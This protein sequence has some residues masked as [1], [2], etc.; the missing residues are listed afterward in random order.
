MQYKTEERNHDITVPLYKTSADIPDS[1]YISDDAIRNELI[2]SLYKS[3]QRHLNEPN[4]RIDSSVHNPQYWICGKALAKNNYGSITIPYISAELEIDFNE[5]FNVA[6][7]WLN[8][9]AI[10]R[11]VSKDEVRLALGKIIGANEADAIFL[12]LVL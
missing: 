4:T 2:S 12:S 10:L 1:I 9:N 3:V 11:G 7:L 5:C 6:H 8:F